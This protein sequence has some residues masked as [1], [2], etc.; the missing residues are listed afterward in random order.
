MS[1]V[2]TLSNEPLFL[3]L[4]QPPSFLSIGRTITAGSFN[5]S[6]QNQI[7]RRNHANT[8]AD[9]VARNITKNKEA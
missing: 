1:I 5:A 3:Q 9:I 8:S 7:S 2:P 4:V 6:Q